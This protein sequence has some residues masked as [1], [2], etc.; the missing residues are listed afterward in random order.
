MNVMPR[1][2]RKL[3]IVGT[4]SSNFFSSFTSNVL[5]ARTR[6]FL[7]DIRCCGLQLCSETEDPLDNLSLDGGE[8]PHLPGEAWDD[9]NEVMVGLMDGAAAG[10]GENQLVAALA[11]DALSPATK[12]L[13]AAVDNFMNWCS[14]L[15]EQPDSCRS[16]RENSKA[17]T[18]PGHDICL[19]D[20]GNEIVVSDT[21]FTA[22]S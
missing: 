22:L 21:A 12:A 4:F 2:R 18:L 9:D 16:D 14:E 20:S 10:T 11:A 17:D 5:C 6:K 7:T 19:Q 8:I 15:D 1:R 13:S 3:S